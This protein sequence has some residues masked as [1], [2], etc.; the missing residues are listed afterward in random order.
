MFRETS[1]RRL[2]RW[3]ARVPYA[4]FALL[5]IAHAP[6]T[7]Q[8]QQLAGR[9]D[10]F[11]QGELVRIDSQ[12]VGR[13]LSQRGGQ[14][15]VALGRSDLRIG[16]SDTIGVSIDSVSIERPIGGGP[17][18][19][20]GALLGG[21]GFGVLGY[22]MGP[23]LGWGSH[24][25]IG[26]P[27]DGCYPRTPA[28]LKRDARGEGVLFF[29]LAGAGLGFLIGR[30]LPYKWQQASPSPALSIQPVLGRR[31]GFSASLALGGH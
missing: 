15:T 23:E 31:L 29:G 10:P 22:F 25:G 4:L 1:I 26:C 30:A 12:I 3:Q 24:A 21:L 27:F 16:R 20:W 28:E 13:V 5:L 18:P 11:S 17:H 6:L 2:Q 19:G 8:G 14:L 7:A 9:T